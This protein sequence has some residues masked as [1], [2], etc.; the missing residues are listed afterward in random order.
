VNGVDPQEINVLHDLENSNIYRG[1]LFSDAIAFRKVVRHYAVKRGF[2]FA[3][4]QTDKTRFITKCK[5]E[6]CPWII[7]ASR[8]FDGKI[9]QVI[10]VYL[11]LNILTMY[12]SAIHITHV[13]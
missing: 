7:H 1:A 9:I 11:V 12:L 10:F 2:K 13:F 4:M 8:V 6:G 3:G 5:S